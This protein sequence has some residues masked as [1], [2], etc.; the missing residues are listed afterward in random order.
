VT[1]RRRSRFTSRVRDT[2]RSYQAGGDIHVYATGPPPAD[3]DRADGRIWNVARPVATFTAR[4]TE[5]D[6]LTRALGRRTGGRV[7]VHGLPGVGKTQLA[8]AW[9]HRHV[10]DR[11]KVV[12]QVRAASRID[13]VADLA[14]LADLLAVGDAD[15]EN[16][17]NQVLHLLNG[18][19][20]W[21]LLYDDAT[22]ASV[23]GLLPARGGRVLLTSRS[24]AWDTVARPFEV[25]P[26]TDE[27]AAAF[28][29]QAA[30]GPGEAARQLAEQLGYLPLALEQARAYCA[31]TGRGIEAYLAEYRRE[32]LLHH[33][34][35]DGLHP[36]VTATLA[37]ALAEA[38]RREP[39]A[40][41]LMTLLA[42][43]APTD[44]PVDLMDSLPFPLGSLVRANRVRVDRMVAVLRDLALVTVGRPGLLR[45][46]QL[47]AEIVRDNARPWATTTYGL[48]DTVL[49][50]LI[51]R[52]FNELTVVTLLRAAPDDPDD[53][54]TWDR[55]ALIL[56]HV[57]AIAGRFESKLATALY[58]LAGLYLLERGEL[59]AARRLQEH[60]Y[61]IRRRILGEEHHDTL[62]TANN[63]GAVLLQQGELAAA[64][65]LHR[66]VHGIRRR[67][68]GDDHH[69]TLVSANNLAQVLR[70]QDELEEA[71]ELTLHTYE[72]RRRSFGDDHVDTI[73]VANNLAVL[74]Q[75]R[76][77]LD[78]ARELMLRA[79]EAIRRRLG[80]EHPH[81]LKTAN[82]LA[83]L[84]LD[85]GDPVAARHLHER[86]Y[87]TSRRVL[88]EEHLD[89]LVSANNLAEV[90]RKQGDTSAARQLHR[91]TYEIRRRV[92]GDDHPHTRS[93]RNAVNR[94]AGRTKPHGKRR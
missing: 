67:A 80:E 43:L 6:G 23:A 8:L 70:Q 39:A 62:V 89:T 20:D 52:R 92:L 59:D 88:G 57:Q 21:V 48:R 42:Q 38:G 68:F 26:F 5:L 28:L 60:T 22:P 44:I 27:A 25:G 56:P 29:D 10:A 75:D 87:E 9:V 63:L 18:R 32:R 66:R 35:D 4:D 47:V 93:S 76:G 37:L 19:D 73:T 50:R 36:P 46:H 2:A 14:R 16:A 65:E 1:A 71:Y 40:A 77:D 11:V 64:H 58:N 94:L 72:V 54:R 15:A 12:W 51:R 55:W 49:R 30:D 81:T 33:G 79:Y 86:T 53:P 82:N 84:L 83:N 24:P 74:V 69:E 34:I 78:G 13:A 91:R 7:A 61:D 90:L 45:V 31:T 85:M 41:Q 3:R 17:A